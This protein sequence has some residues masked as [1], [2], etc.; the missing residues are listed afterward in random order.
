[1]HVPKPVPN[2]CTACVQAWTLLV[3]W[4][5]IHA[6]ALAWA[7]VYISKQFPRFGTPTF[8]AVGGG[9]GGGGGHK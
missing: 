4:R 5:C 8:I 1:M 9:G 3:H 7:H 2:L 6:W